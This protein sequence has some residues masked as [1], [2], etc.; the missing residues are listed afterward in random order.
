MQPKISVIVPV[1]RAE[2]YL[3]ACLDSILRQTYEQLQI[4]L[5]DDGSPD[6]CGEICDAYAVKDPRIQVIHQPNGGVAKARNAGLDAATGDWIGWVD[7]DDWIDPDMLGFLLENALAEDADVC[8]CGR[9]EEL[10]GGTG[11]FGFSQRTLLDPKG[12][13]RALLEAKVLDDALYDKLWKRRL[14]EGIRFPEG[15]TYEDLA[16]VYRLLGKAERVLCLPEPK[17]HYRHRPGSIMADASLP[18]RMNHYHFARQRYEDLAEK[19]PEFQ[20]LLEERCLTAAVGIW[21]GYYRNPRPVRCQYAAQLHQIAVYAKSR[22][23][24]ALKRT[25]SGLAG[26]LVLRLLPYDKGW[27]FRLAAFIGGLYQRKHGRTL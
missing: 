27:A 22:V 7:S 8:I 6:R 5:V 4:I 18:N 3:E 12:T 13:V 23:Q 17:Y 1:Y 24:P 21:C 11:F 20:P 19:W 2:A 25:G 10:P 9:H 26:R 14:F 16:T 15:R